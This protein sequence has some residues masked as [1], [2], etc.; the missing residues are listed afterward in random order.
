[1][2]GALDRQNTM[3]RSNSVTQ[4]MIRVPGVVGQE[5]MPAMSAIQ[6]AGLNVSVL[7]AK[8]LPKDMKG[9]VGMEG[10]VV[11]QTPGPGGLAMYGTTV[12]IYVWK[13]NANAAAAGSAG[14]T[15]WGT[16]SPSSSPGFS[17][18]PGSS[19]GAGVPAQQVYP[20]GGV[21][22][23][24]MQQPSQ[25]FQ[26][27][28]YYY[29]GAGSPQDQTNMGQP[30]VDPNAGQQA[31]PPMDPNAGQQAMPPQNPQQPAPPGQ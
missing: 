5:Q 20:Q 15:T 11:T 13:P 25:P 4:S 21:Q 7:E 1:M 3:P 8:K 29:P 18:F 24:Q 14:A 16:S 28:Q 26:V 17:A 27:Q 31:Q 30:P 19:P 23:G 2:A 10:K 22:G 9:A 6:Q 12:T